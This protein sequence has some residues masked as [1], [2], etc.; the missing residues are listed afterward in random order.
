MVTD[1]LKKIWNLIFPHRNI[2]IKDG[3][4]VASICTNNYEGKNMSDGERVALYLIALALC[5]P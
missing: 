1:K 2:D 4:V 3:K 5:A